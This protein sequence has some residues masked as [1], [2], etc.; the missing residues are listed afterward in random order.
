MANLLLTSYLSLII[1]IAF[2]MAYDTHLEERINH[3]L[4]AK[5]VVF[6]VKKMMGGLCYMVDGKMLCGIIK[7]E[8]MARVGQDKYKA[9]LAMDGVNPKLHLQ[10][11]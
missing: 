8:L 1:A 5:K 9:C 2:S 11:Q 3:V 4:Q 6:N 10:D 7:N